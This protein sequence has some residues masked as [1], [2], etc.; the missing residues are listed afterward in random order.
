MYIKKER[1]LRMPAAA[2]CF[3]Y[4]DQATGT[5]VFFSGAVDGDSLVTLFFV[6][7]FSVGVSIID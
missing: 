3:C 2:K 6:C 1:K 7:L 5:D 4:R